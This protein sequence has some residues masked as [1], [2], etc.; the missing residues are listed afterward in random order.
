MSQY[1][2]WFD[3]S[4]SSP[5]EDEEIDEEQKQYLYQANIN[6]NNNNASVEEGGEEQTNDTF[7]Q[8]IAESQQPKKKKRKKKK[9][10]KK[11]IDA[12]S[13]N[14]QLIDPENDEYMVHLKQEEAKKLQARLEESKQRAKNLFII[15]F[16]AQFHQCFKMNITKVPAPAYQSGVN[17]KRSHFAMAPYGTNLYIFGGKNE[18]SKFNDLLMLNTDENVWKKIP[19]ASEPTSLPSLNNP[20]M[21]Q[22]GDDLIVHDVAGIFYVLVDVLLLKKDLEKK[23]QEKKPLRWTTASRAH[24]AVLAT[25][26]ASCTVGTQVYTFGGSVNGTSCQAFQHFYFILNNTTQRNQEHMPH[27]ETRYSRIMPHAYYKHN[28]PHPRSKHGMVHLSGYIYVF[29]GVFESSMA[30]LNEVLGIKRIVF[31]DFHCYDVDK[32][33]WTEVE[34]KGVAPPPLYGFTM[35]ALN[36]FIYIYGGYNAND[37]AQSTLYRFDVTTCTWSVVLI[38]GPAHPVTQ[39]PVDYQVSCAYHSAAFINYKLIVVGGVHSTESSNRA[40]HPNNC[41]YFNGM[42]EHGEAKHMT[43]Y[44]WESV[45]QNRYSDLHLR[46]ANRATG[47]AVYFTVHRAVLAIRSHYFEKILEEFESTELSEDGTPI[48]EIVDFYADT[49]EAFLSFL[50]KGE[51][52]IQGSQQIADLIR[53]SEAWGHFDVIERLCSVDGRFLDLSAKVMN[54]LSR[55]FERLFNESLEIFDES[56]C[57]EDLNTFDV[58]ANKSAEGHKKYTDACV[59]LLDENEQVVMKITGHKIFLCRSPHIHNAFNS[60]MEESLSGNIQFVNFA[61]R[62][63]LLGVMKFLYTDEIDI[64]P[65]VALEVLLAS[66]MF[67]LPQLSSYCCSIIM[68]NVIK[69]NVLQILDIA[70]TY[71]HADLKRCCL[72]FFMR[73]WEDLR[74]DEMFS[75]LSDEIR[76]NVDLILIPRQVKQELK[77]KRREQLKQSKTKRRYY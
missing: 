2:E 38:R 67:V 59:Q 16:A 56:N 30:K 11:N 19:L 23:D 6:N 32:N 61:D 1:L 45:T 13:T 63:G 37:E 24:S 66:Q 65:S 21:L 5:S 74:K 49:V 70:D 62:D 42:H 44:L 51:I 39:S 34:V 31:N 8:L 28:V 64:S 57:F 52:K 50:Y 47:E 41:L 72:N 60:G 27:Y 40:V 3:E 29:G 35:N 14:V 12:N 22:I 46:C 43:D 54:D 18:Q 68:E 26:Y 69:E 17:L 4:Y 25:D 36:N 48:L 15:D 75:F 71:H 76:K 55:D 58:L 20:S 33:L 10:A 77:K 53:C 73:H 9:K 7:Y